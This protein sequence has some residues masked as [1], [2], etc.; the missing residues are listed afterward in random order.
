[1]R[2]ERISDL[3]KR[4]YRS[5]DTM[6]K[7]KELISLMN[8]NDL[9]EI[10]VQED[11]FRIKVRRSNGVQPSVLPSHQLPGAMEEGQ[12][13]LPRKDNFLEIASPMVGTFYKAPTPGAEPFV[14]VGDMVDPETVV[15]VIEAM[16]IINEIKAELSGKVVEVLVEDGKAVE[17]GQ[18]LFRVFPLSPEQTAQQR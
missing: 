16:K 17:Y 9:A 3:S 5:M 12:R 11:T 4:V 14:G 6:N 18:P 10:E 1:M 15:C 2:L 8:T 7:I 13:L